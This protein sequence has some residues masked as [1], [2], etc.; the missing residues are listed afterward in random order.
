MIKTGRCVGFEYHFMTPSSLIPGLDEI[1]RNGDPTNPP[2]TEANAVTIEPDG[3]ILA[4]G[5]KAARARGQSFFLMGL[6][7][8]V[9]S[10]YIGAG[11]LA[12]H[13]LA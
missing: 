1:V 11:L 8:V 3:K 12:A 6:M 13:V 4:A 7:A 10:V 9:L 5:D 2:Q